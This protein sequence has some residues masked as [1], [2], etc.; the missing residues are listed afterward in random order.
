MDDTDHPRPSWAAFLFPALQFLLVAA[1]VYVFVS[2]EYAPPAAITAAGVAIDHQY[3]MTLAVTAVAFVLSQLG[4]A[5]VVL[6]YRDHGQRVQFSRGNN[7]FELL[8]TSLTA[9]VFIGLGLLGAKAWASAR[10]FTPAPDA[11]R[12]EVT[13]NQF[14]FN[15]RYAGPDGK[16][17][18]LDPR[19]VDA[20]AGNPI[21]LDPGDPTGNDDIVVPTLT[22]PVNQEIEL[23]LRSQDVI[24]SFFV[25]ELRLQQDAVPG[26]IVPVRFKA[27]K[28]GH[29]EVVCTQLCGLGHSNMHTYLDVVS[30]EDFAT[31]LKNGG[32]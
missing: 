9:V 25:R 8:W 28:I 6:K 24:H 4:L 15:F 12:I 18:R 3:D 13:E 26:L 32:Q 7:T 11:V 5:F 20:S 16:F 31:F 27:E 30:Q 23:L 21:G 17:G 10:M 29:Y 2:K 1:T 14:V 22:V 19:K